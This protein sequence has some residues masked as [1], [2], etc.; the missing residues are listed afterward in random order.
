MDLSGRKH[1]ESVTTYDSESD[2]VTVN[3]AELRELIE[4]AKLTMRY[5]GFREYVGTQVANK[6]QDALQPFEGDK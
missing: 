3:R 6:L 2:A 4:A 1:V 5:P